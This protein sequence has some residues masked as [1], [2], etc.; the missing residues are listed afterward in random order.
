MQRVE[1]RKSGNVFWKINASM[2]NDD[3]RWITQA[4]QSPQENRETHFLPNQDTEQ[5]NE[6]RGAARRGGEHPGGL[7]AGEQ[8]LIV[9]VVF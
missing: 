8:M 2:V 9:D 4:A 6:R 5:E 7:R 3:Q 1:N